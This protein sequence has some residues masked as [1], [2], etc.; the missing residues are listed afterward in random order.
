MRSFSDI[1]LI[2][3]VALR[4]LDLILYSH[5]RLTC[6]KCVEQ[7][8]DAGDLR[9][10]SQVRTF[11]QSEA[12]FFTTVEP[13]R[14]SMRHPLFAEIGRSRAAAIGQKRSLHKPQPKRSAK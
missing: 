1:L 6:F 10:R 12:E 9:F 8:G 13:K 5:N 2:Q 3:T 4:L 14:L 11:S 7:P